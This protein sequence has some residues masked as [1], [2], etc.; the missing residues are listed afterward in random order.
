VLLRAVASRS[1]A[2]G[3]GDLMSGTLMLAFSGYVRLENAPVALLA[4]ALATLVFL[5]SAVLINSAAFWLADIESISLHLFNFLLAFATYPPTLFGGITKLILF[6]V[7]PA[8]LV[9]YLPVELLR[10]FR[11]DRALLALGGAL[12]Y[13]FLAA[14]VFTLG[15]RRYASGS[16]FGV[17]G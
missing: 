5:S 6:T 15:L 8:G 7:I 14:L 17:W 13:A 4:I 3:W 9:S 1:N 12:S 10:E 16:R 11:P 2:S